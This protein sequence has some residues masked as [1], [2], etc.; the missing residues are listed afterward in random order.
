MTGDMIDDFQGINAQ[1][2][3]VMNTMVD[4]VTDVTDTVI[5]SKIK[6]WMCPTKR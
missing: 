5:P 6:S 3:K 2:N 1:F 4:L